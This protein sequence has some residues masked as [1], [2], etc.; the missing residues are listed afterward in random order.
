MNDTSKKEKPSDKQRRILLCASQ[1]FNR[2]ALRFDII[3]YVLSMVQLAGIVTCTIVYQS[4]PDKV[5]GS[6]TRP[7][8]L[9]AAY[10]S[11]VISA[12]LG[13]TAAKA[14][15]AQCKQAS[16]LILRAQPDEKTLN[17]IHDIRIPLHD[18]PLIRCQW[19]ME[20]KRLVVTERPSQEV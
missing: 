10:S 6:V 2:I 1:D 13:L 17:I 3:F 8:G 12:L 16:V 19:R 9:A 11:T 4:L 14:T 5:F 18:N 7:I 20:N 15:S